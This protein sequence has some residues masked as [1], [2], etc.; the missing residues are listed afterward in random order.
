MIRSGLTGRGDFPIVAHSYWE[1][2]AI[3]NR[4]FLAD[5]RRGDFQSLYLAMTNSVGERRGDFQ[6]QVSNRP[7]LMDE[8]RG[9]FQSSPL[10]LDPPAVTQEFGGW[11][12]PLLRRQ[13]NRR[14][15]V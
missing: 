3:S 4:S 2:R 10:F 8:R 7:F 9:D 13:E 6:S 1:R 14:L 11:K 12:P 15:S 5:E